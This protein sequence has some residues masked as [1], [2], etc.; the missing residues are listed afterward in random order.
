VE[1]LTG[2]S[3]GPGLNLGLVCWIFSPTP[4]PYTTDMH[5]TYY[6]LMNTTDFPPPTSEQITPDI[7]PQTTG[8]SKPYQHFANF[9]NLTRYICLFIMY[10]E[11]SELVQWFG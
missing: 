3:R 11:I 2:D 4:T 10:R 1:H 5:K 7:K 8:I 9:Y 6:L